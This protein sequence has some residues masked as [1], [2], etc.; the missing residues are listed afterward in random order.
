[1]NTN[2]FKIFEAVAANGSFTK[3]AEAMFTV[4]SNVT[5]RIKS[6][7]D[8][9][10]VSLFTR[11]SRK[12]ELTAAGETLM[13]YF[14]QIGQLIEEAKR[15]LAQSDQL[16]GQLRIGCIETTM[17]LKAPDMINKFNEMYPDIELEFKA[18]MSPNLINDVLNY[19]LDAAFVAAPVSVPE[20]AQQTI[21]EEQ[22][23][24]VAS[25]KYKKIEELIQDKQV[26]I[27]VFDQG[28]NYRAR[29]ESWL[30]FKG[31]VNYKRI[32]VNSLEG[33]INFVEA[34]LAITILPAELI[35]QYYQNRKLKTFS[36]GK[37]LGTSA[38]ILVYR[39]TRLKDKLLAAFLEMY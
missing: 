15:E 16:I 21:K 19:K 23:V 9:F 18:D 28:C 6:L 24:M 30:S 8:E 7:E 13:H 12:V 5:A 17:A 31:V 32:V 29:L 10:A 33:I 34:D 14:K 26:K 37:E 22:L 20:L 35:E 3:A 36:I 39:K 11:T 1:M 38:T 25:T 2:D 4:Q 27:V